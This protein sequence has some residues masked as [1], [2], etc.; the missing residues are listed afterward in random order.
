[1]DVLLEGGI[2]MPEA[3]NVDELVRLL[4]C[5]KDTCNACS[6]KLWP[7]HCSSCMYTGLKAKIQAHIEAIV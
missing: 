2:R 6:F 1:M 3:F 5:I 4:G 7:S